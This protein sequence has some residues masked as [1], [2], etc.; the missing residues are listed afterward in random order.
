MNYVMIWIGVKAIFEKARNF[1]LKHIKLIVAI[2]AMLAIFALGWFGCQYFNKNVVV[3][4]NTVTVEKQVPVQIPVEV[5]GDTQVV[6]VPK[7]SPSDADV[8]IM[9]PA[10]VVVMEYNGQEYKMPT[11]QGETH[12]FDKGKLDVEQSSKTTLDVTPIVEREVNTAIDK[13]K[14]KDEITKNDAVQEEKHKAHKHGQ[15]TFLYGLGAGLVA[16]LVL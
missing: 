2:V 16:G 4:E 8:S 9:N 7:K 14:A 1:V 15:K 13:Q 3:V 12:K 6:Y 5:K 11:V 10:P